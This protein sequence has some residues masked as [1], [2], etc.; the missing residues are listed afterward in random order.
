MP[1]SKYHNLS[2]SQI[3][4]NFFVSLHFLTS[5]IFIQPSFSQTIQPYKSEIDSTIINDNSDNQLTANFDTIE[6]DPDP[7]E[8]DYLIAIHKYIIDNEE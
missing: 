7:K 3:P 5:L 4:K 6:Y 1:L 2:F 8:S